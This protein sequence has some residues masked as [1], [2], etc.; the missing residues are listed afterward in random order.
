MNSGIPMIESMTAFASQT[1][2]G[3]WGSANWDIRSVNHRYLECIIRLPESLQSLEPKIRD[4]VRQYV[5]RGK[6][7]LNLHYN[8]SEANTEIQINA[9]LTKQL[10]HAQNEISRHFRL[11][12][13]FDSSRLLNWPGL[14]SI[15][16]KEMAPVEQA[17]LQMLK[18]ALENLVKA[19]QTE[20][21]ALKELIDERLIAIHAEVAKVKEHLPKILTAH[22]QKLT[23][24][25][26]EIEQTLEPA[27]FEQEMLILIQKSDVAEELDRLVTHVNEASNVLQQDGV[28]GRRLDFLLQE[29][30]RE[31]NTLASKSMATETTHVAVELK[32]LI[33]QMREQAQNIC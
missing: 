19:R 18:I 5:K 13:P 16:E 12:A 10:A 26:N 22:R 2:N 3:D 24:K 21:K 6:L 29:M 20:G 27:R 7:D 15:I 32:V 30:N 8:P 17:I 23:E 31:A 1:T 4:I 28:I 9:D 25:L 14:L 33:E 11:V